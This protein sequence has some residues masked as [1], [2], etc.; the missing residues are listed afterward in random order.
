MVDITEIMDMLDWYMPL[1]I[2][3]NISSKKY[4]N[5]YSVYT[6]ANTKTQ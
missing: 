1:G 3:R 2:R 5:N 4:R 6:T